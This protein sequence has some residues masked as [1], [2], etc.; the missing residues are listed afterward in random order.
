MR[1]AIKELANVFKNDPAVASAAGGV[2]TPRMANV[3]ADNPLTKAKFA[4]ASESFHRAKAWMPTAKG[5][6]IALVRKTAQVLD[7]P[8][9]SKTVKE[10]KELAEGQYDIDS[11]VEE[12][13]KEAA[14]DKADTGTARLRMFGDGNVLTGKGAGR[15]HSINPSNV[16]TTQIIE[17][18][19]EATGINI[20][21]KV[22]MDRALIER[23][24][25]AAQLG[26]DKLRLLK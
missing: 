19:S 13:I 17:E 9:H 6:A 1:G 24:Y 4:L 26:A 11:Y 18:V 10:L 7:N 3:M 12:L 21:D 25:T 2:H 14:R 22:A 5:R 16:A 8:L 15:Q 23:G 20:A